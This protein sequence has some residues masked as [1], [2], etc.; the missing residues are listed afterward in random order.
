MEG[1]TEGEQGFSIERTTPAHIGRLRCIIV[2]LPGVLPIGDTQMSDVKTKRGP[3][4]RS[5]INIH[6]DHEL[7]YWTEKF[8]VTRDELRAVVRRAG[9]YV[10]A[11][12][13]E[14]KSGRE[15]QP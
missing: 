5:R 6:E 9:T 4:D 10:K 3:Q 2:P 14:L 13:A 11:V 12:E 1:A 15:I 8:R 7:A